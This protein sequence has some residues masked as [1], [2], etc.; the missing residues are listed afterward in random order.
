MAES[1]STRYRLNPPG[2]P[3]ALWSLIFGVAGFC[4]PLLGGLVAVVLGGMGMARARRT[5]DG[6]A[7]ALTGLV[8][9][10]L[11]IATYAVIGAGLLGLIGLFTSQSPATQP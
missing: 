11:S 9:G 5:L 3:Y 6:N 7:V 4:L 1:T 2:N 10:L 8:L